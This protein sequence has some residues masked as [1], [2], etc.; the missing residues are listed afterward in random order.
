MLSFFSLYL[1][2]Y[3]LVD[4]HNF[5]L[6]LPPV[7][8]LCL[9]VYCQKWYMRLFFV[10]L[11]VIISCFFYTGSS[12]KGLNFLRHNRC[13]FNLT[14]MHAYQ[15]NFRCLISFSRETYYSFLRYGH[16]GYQ[17]AWIGHDNLK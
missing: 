8:T 14:K 17:I 2:A 10:E 5:G 15:S 6:Q 7:I 12:K 3:L 4:Q 11:V 9:I 13:T 1:E 16:L